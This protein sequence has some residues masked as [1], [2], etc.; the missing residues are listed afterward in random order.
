MASRAALE[1]VLDADRAGSLIAARHHPRGDLVGGLEPD[2]RMSRARQGVRLD[3]FDRALAARLKIR[4]ARDDETPWLWRKTMISHDW[5]RKRLRDRA[6]PAPPDL[7]PQGPLRAMTVKTSLPNFLTSRAANA[8]PIPLMS[9]DARYRSIPS[10]LSGAEV[11]I[12]SALNCGPCLG[13]TFHFP[14]AE[15]HSPTETAGTVPTT[16]QSS[17][18]PLTLTF[19]T[20]KPDSSLW[21]VTL[22]T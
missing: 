6:L 9:P 17:L 7:D 4:Y 15:S 10:A 13:S 2:P 1:R 22:S 19:S 14:V 16:V 20:E 21:N 18:R 11:R 3:R 12:C 8:G 5:V